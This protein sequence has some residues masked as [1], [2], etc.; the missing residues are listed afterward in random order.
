M[1][2]DYE[3][4]PDKAQINLQ[5]HGVRFADAREVFRDER[6]LTV[7]DDFPFEQRFITIGSDI[8]GRLLVVVFTWRGDAI[9]IISARRA[10]RQEREQYED[11]T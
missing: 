4:D 10:N 9:R 5:K 11:N 6:A 2:I 8:T 7:E 3:W 1:K